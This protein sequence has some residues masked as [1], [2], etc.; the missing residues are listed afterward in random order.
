MI[1]AV[2]IDI[3]EIERVRRA[4]DNPRTGGRFRARV[5]TAAEIAYCL[6]RR[7]AGESFAARFAAKE[8]VMKALGRGMGD[9]IGWHDI[10][11]VRTGGRPF[12]VVRGRALECGRE[13][14]IDRW[15]LS[16]AHTATHAVAT[17][18]G[19]AAGGEAAGTAPPQPR[20]R[21]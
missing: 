5:F 1:V 21:G 11:V 15:H 17:A 2:G 7:R 18:I 12:V 9:G 8:A 16:L 19:E 4:L 10:E 14:G 13:Q 20:P 6:E 3:V